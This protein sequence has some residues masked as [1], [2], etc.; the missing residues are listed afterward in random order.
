MRSVRLPK[1]K[2]GAKPAKEFLVLIS[3]VLMIIGCTGCG[4]AITARKLKQIDLPTATA[5]KTKKSLTFRYLEFTDS[6]EEFTA[7]QN[8]R[9]ISSYSEAISEATRQALKGRLED[10]GLFSKIDSSKVNQ[11]KEW[12]L[13]VAEEDLENIL[14]IDREDYD[15]DYFLDVSNYRN[16]GGKKYLWAI[17]PTNI[18][19][20]VTYGLLPCYFPVLEIQLIGNLYDK[21][22]KLIATFQKTNAASV[23]FWSPLLLWPGEETRA[24]WNVRVLEDQLIARTLDHMIVELSRNRV[25]SV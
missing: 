4:T 5:S 25:F 2:V 8:N 17:L 21:N 13:S 20:Y 24:T 18:L 19:C 23:W 11:R 14:K 3:L 1:K 16:Y 7:D 10:Q 12:I 15:T 6:Y 22:R 9:E